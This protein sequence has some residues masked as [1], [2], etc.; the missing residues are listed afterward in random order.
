MILKYISKFCTA[1][2]INK[3]Q[4]LCTQSINDTSV[5]SNPSLMDL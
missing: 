1:F 2:V 5:H 3:N 4:F